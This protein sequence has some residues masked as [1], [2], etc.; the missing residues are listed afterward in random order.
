MGNRAVIT[1]SRALEPKNSQDIGV[2]LHWNGGRCS[3][4]AFLKYCKLKGY[5]SPE[6]DCYGY[7]RL[8]QVIGN[9]FGGGL[10]LGVGRCCDLDCD[11]YDNGTYI[12]KDWE[13]VD[14]KYEPTYETDDYDLYDMLKEIDSRQP[15]GEQLGEFLDAREIPIEEV[16]VGDI[17]FFFD[18]IRDKYETRIVVGFG[19]E[20]RGWMKTLG[21]P[22][23]DKYPGLDG[24][25]EANC[26]NY[27]KGKT[28]RV[29]R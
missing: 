9:F 13:I 6:T 29:L 23:V 11:N 5:R 2:Y 22:Y 20:D 4:E 7:A 21:V 24:N 16:Q 28:V 27:I 1:A 3:V 25:Y 15:V 18:D 8:C 17:V 26:N 14:R 19:K 12:I 10:S